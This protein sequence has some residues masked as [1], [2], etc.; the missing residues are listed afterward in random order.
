M[1][2]SSGCQ[3]AAAWRL[4]LH[5]LPLNCLGGCS[6][7]MRCAV[8]TRAVQSDTRMGIARRHGC[9]PTSTRIRTPATTYLQLGTTF[10]V[11]SSRD[12]LGD[13]SQARLLPL[14]GEL[15]RQPQPRAATALPARCEFAVLPSREL[16]CSRRAP[17]A[18]CDGPWLNGRAHSAYQLERLLL[19]ARG[20]LHA[21][22]T[23]RPLERRRA[24]RFDTDV[25]R[26]ARAR[27]AN[28]GSCH[29]ADS[30]L[31]LCNSAV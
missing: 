13:A 7:E 24:R 20:L 10:G 12:R 27:L 23:A 9:V 5:S 22:R 30:S 29:E 25:G 1:Q 16:G 6:P 3:S 26:R 31:A 28:A 15:G 17:L 18:G 19:C 11:G 4:W 14:L 21:S 8:H 2:R